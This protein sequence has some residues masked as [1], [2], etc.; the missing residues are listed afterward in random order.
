VRRDWELDTLIDAWTLVEADHELIANKYGAS[1]LGFCLLLKFFEIEGRFPRHAG[2]VPPAAVE[3]LAR[4]VKVDPA[5]F[6]AYAFSGRTIEYHRHQIRAALGFREATHGDRDKL[7]VWLAEQVWPSELDTDRQRQALL[8][9]CR[10]ER[11]EPPGRGSI[12]KILG[13]ANRAADEQFCAAIVGRLPEPA[14]AALD[15]LVAEGDAD[16]DAE[17]EEA[18]GAGEGEGGGAE[19]TGLFTELKAD[20]GPLGLESLLTEVARLRRVHTLGLPADLLADIADKRVAAWRARAAN[21]YPST[22]RRDHHR[23]V[24]LTLL[25]VL[26]WCRQVELTDGLV[27]LFIGLVQ[28]CEEQRER[29]LR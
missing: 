15:K 4:Q 27:E 14:I 20:P 16:A 1:K 6:A 17:A 3:Y 7:A 25:A 9:K 2:E 10:A 19:P 18:D 29:I 8:A 23:R 12:D 11:I 26:C 22:L 24:R 21:E 28:G 13:A 5:D